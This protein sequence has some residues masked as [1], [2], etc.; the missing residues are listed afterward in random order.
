MKRVPVA[1]VIPCCWKHVYVLKE[2]IEAIHE[3]TCRPSIIVV[4]LSEVPYENNGTFLDSNRYAIPVVVLTSNNKQNQSMNRNN[5]MDYIHEYCK[6]I[7]WLAFCDADDI[8][9]C[10][11]LEMCMQ[12]IEEYGAECVLHAFT[13]RCGGTLS[14]VEMKEYERTN[15]ETLHLPIAGLHHAHVVIHKRIGRVIRYNE[16]MNF[17]EDS[18]FVR[19]IIQGGYA[20]VYIGKKLVNYRHTHGGT[21]K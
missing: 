9:S 1:V 10:N 18:R 20:T 15:R 19:D 12:S 17:G 4:S 7:L 8:W 14:P 2:C 6:D 3:Q 5:C 16:T 21:W 13:T 11:K